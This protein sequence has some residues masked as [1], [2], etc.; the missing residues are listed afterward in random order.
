[1]IY[2]SDGFLVT[3][4]TALG[5]RPTIVLPDGSSRSPIRVASD[6]VTGLMLLKVAAD[7]L[8][9]VQLTN[10]HVKSGDNVFAAGFDQS[11]APGQIGGQ[12]IASGPASP[13]DAPALIRIDMSATPGFIGGV[14]SNQAGQ[15][16]GLTKADRQ[17]AGTNQV[18]AIPTNY[19]ISWIDSWRAQNE[20]ALGNSA[21]WPELV[22]GPSV[23]LRYPAGWSVDNQ[24]RDGRTFQAEITPGDPDV[25]AKL[26]ISIQPSDFQGEPLAYAEKEFGNESNATIW[27][28][29]IYGQI[30]GVRVLVNQEGA[31]V[32][33]VYL[34]ARGLRIGVSM[35]S[36]Y[37]TGNTGPQEQRITALFDGVL[38]SIT[39]SPSEGTPT[40]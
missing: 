10:G 22:A 30:H 37:S 11:N 14:L 26:S 32:D 31:R 17:D 40:S 34:F 5:K 8:A 35:T 33:V 16:V 20:Q 27:G 9:P 19:V 36:G 13:S 1:M 18:V 23:T 38:R 3:I 6:P 12:V 4:D 39:L 25:P 21:T 15:V 28:S 29:V 7:S 24:N 2:S